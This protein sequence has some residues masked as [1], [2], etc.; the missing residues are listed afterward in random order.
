MLHA[1][2]VTQSNTDES[3]LE[4]LQKGF[5]GRCIRSGCKGLEKT[6]QNVQN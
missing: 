2:Q 6:Y 5:Q 4:E 1:A 3:R